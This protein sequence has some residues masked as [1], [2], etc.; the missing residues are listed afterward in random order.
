MAEEIRL[1]QL[2]TGMQEAIILEWLRAEGEP[3]VKG[4]PLFQVETDKAV[5]EVEA[6]AGGVLRSILH[7]KGEKVSIDTIVAIIE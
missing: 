5:V 2:G 6:P 1:T 4:E 7:G 3:V